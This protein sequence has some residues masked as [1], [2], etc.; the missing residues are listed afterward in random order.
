MTPWSH[1]HNLQYIL[2]CKTIKQQ[3]RQVGRTSWLFS[4]SECTAFHSLASRET[5]AS[6]YWRRNIA[7][8]PLINLHLWH[9]CC[10]EK[11]KQCL[12]EVTELCCCCCCSPSA[13]S[14][15]FRNS[16]IHY[17]AS[18]ALH[19]FRLRWSGSIKTQSKKK[20]RKRRSR[21]DHETSR[22]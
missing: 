5:E 4:K 15:L 20:N 2:D 12:S 16:F 3:S 19:W 6:L 1:L 21:T 8:D 13:S 11:N 9:T 10:C 17:F 14:C 18:P 7:C 22:F